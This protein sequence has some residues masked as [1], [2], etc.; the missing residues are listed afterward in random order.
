VLTI[1][2][3]SS[4]LELLDKQNL[5]FISSKLGVDYLTEQEIHTLQ[6]YGINPYHLYKETNDIAK[7]SFHFGMISD[8]INEIDAKKI[9]YNDLVKYFNEGYH[10]P[11]T[12]VEKN[13]IESIKKQYLGDI[14][15]NNGKVFQDINNIIGK[16]EK[17]NRNAYESVI[18]NEVEKGILAKKTSQEIA[19]ELARKTGDWSRNFKRI[20]DFISHT[21][22]DEG[23]A[24]MIQDKYGN[25]SLVYKQVYQGACKYC[26]KAYLTGDIGSEPR[27]FKLS[28]LKANGTNIGR[29][30]DEYK[31]VI[32]ST[33]PNCRC[34]LMIY[35]PSLLWDNKTKGFNLPN[36][37]RNEGQKVNPNRKPIR[38]TVRGKEYLV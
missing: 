10:I 25:D 30:P 4:L 23:R 8:A 7:M 13:T 33:H 3:I 11:L 32:G 6:M 37:K 5:I 36:P 17:N 15:A 12:V 18:R 9:D 22:Y 28:T 29:K 2:Q 31:P 19:R 27:V 20:V 34:Q 26:V 1:Q 21:A 35:N 24:A 38:I 16:H 14:K